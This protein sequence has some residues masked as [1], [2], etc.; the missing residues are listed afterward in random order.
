MTDRSVTYDR[1]EIRGGGTQELMD[2][3]GAAL[4]KSA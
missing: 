3:L 1:S 4:A 2:T